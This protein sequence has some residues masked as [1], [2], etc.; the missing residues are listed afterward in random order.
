MMGAKTAAMKR[1][2]T[3]LS[4]FRCAGVGLHSGERVEII[5]RP[6]PAG[7]GIRFSL[8]S[9]SGRVLVAPRPDNV[10]ATVLATTVGCDQARVA[11]VEHLLAALAGMEVDNALVEVHGGEIPIMDG[12]ALRFARLIEAAGVRQLDAPRR[13]ARICR[14]VTFEDGDR[15]I[16]AHPY[17]GLRIEYRIRFPHPSVG[18][19]SYCFDATPQS[20]LKEIAPARTFGFLQDVE[21]LRAAGLARGGSLANAVVLGDVGVLNPEGLR[22]ADEMV[23]HKVLDF[24]GDM[25]VAPYRLCGRFVVE[26]SGHEANNRFLRWLFAHAEQYLTLGETEDRRWF[27]PVQSPMPAPWGLHPSGATA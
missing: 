25:A 3:L 22:F 23:R 16:H 17:P 11:T 8:P 7:S 27:S 18:S 12:S 9:P 6:A 14:P 19:Q 5:V 4:P 21:R 13:V 26:R 24:L 15:S 2:T 10:V 20:F 1:E